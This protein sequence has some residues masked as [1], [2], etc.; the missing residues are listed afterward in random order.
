MTTSVETPM[1]SFDPLFFFDQSETGRFARSMDWS[2]SNLGPAENWPHELKVILGMMFGNKQPVSLFWG[3]ENNYFYNDSYIPIVGRSKHPHTMGQRGEEVWREIWDVLSP[4]IDHVEKKRGATWNVDQYLPILGD[5]G[6]PR[7]AYFTY[8]YSPVFLANGEVGGTLVT[9]TETTEKVLAEKKIRVSHEKAEAS[10]KLL[11]DFFMQSPIP[12][13]IL[14]GPQHHFTLANPPY[15]KLI[16]RKAMGR[17]L[18]DIY[19]REEVSEFLPLLDGVYQTGIPHVGHELP[20]TITAETG[21]LVNLWIDISYYP[22]RDDEG[23]IQGILALILDVTEHRNSRIAVEAEKQKFES[24]FVESPAAMALLKGPNFVYEKVNPSYENIL[25]RKDLIGKA[26]SQTL[27]SI[28]PQD[29]FFQNI[30]KEVF[31]TG[32]AFNGKEML[33]EIYNPLTGNKRSAYFDFTYSRVEDGKGQPYGVFVHAN[34]V[35]DKVETRLKILNAIRMRDEFLSIASHELKTPLTSLKMQLQVARRGVNLDT[36]KVPT[37]E[38][39]ASTLDRSI[40][41][42]DRLTK[43]VDD[44]LDITRLDSGKMEYHFQSTDLTALIREVLDRFPEY[45]GES[46]L[47]FNLDIGPQTMVSCD[48]FRIEQVITNLIS[49]AIKYGEGRPIGISLSSAQNVVRLKIS[50]QGIGIPED[51]REKVFQRFERAVSNTNISGLGLGLYITRQIVEAHQGSIQL[52]SSVGEGST[53]IVELPRK[54][55]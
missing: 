18:L 16:G 34:D 39:L 4:Q 47:Q 6:L 36:G 15:E 42:I 11:Y 10:R 53:F 49:N 54:R 32:T 43:L 48:H 52:V 37:P 31:N 23:Q 25:G 45:A 21:S 8:S 24:I 41:Q 35:T 33:V 27:P 26:R 29:D 19:S 20:L 50:D 55:E 7:D 40:R 17:D 13:V 28:T 12:M 9:C 44:L 5:D 14:H 46:K 2:H 30:M 51:M 22:F 3:P 38:K 1:T